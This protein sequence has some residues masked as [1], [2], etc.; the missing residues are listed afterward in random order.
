MKLRT[1]LIIILCSVIFVPMFF[2]GLI[3]YK[4]SDRIILQHTLNHLKT[5]SILTKARV[6]DVYDRYLEHLRIAVT[7]P[8][9]YRTL[10]D[11]F[12]QDSPETRQAILDILNKF[13]PVLRNAEE[14]YVFDLNGRLISGT[15][16]YWNLK[17]V[18]GEDFFQKGKT[19]EFFDLIKMTPESIYAGR[20]IFAGPVVVNSEPKA[21]LLIML[22]FEPFS[23]IIRTYLKI[24]ESEDIVLGRKNAQGDAEFVTPRR[25][26][27]EKTSLSVVPQ[28][29]KE[30]PM[31]RAVYGE[32][33]LLDNA[34]DYRGHR[35]LAA[36]NYV[37][38]PGI[39]IVVK[40][41]EAEFLK[42]LKEL[43]KITY[44][45]GGIVIFFTIF[46]GLVIARS[47]SAPIVRLSRNANR[48]AKGDLS[49]EIKT[50]VLEDDEI[51]I[52]TRSFGSMSQKLITMNKDLE[53]KVS[54]RTF[55]L[56]DRLHELERLNKISVGRELKMIELKKQVNDLSVKVGLE[57][58][59][60][61]GFLKERTTDQ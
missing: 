61:L 25:F 40:I 9:L 45:F 44:I 56:E 50:G 5:L 51:G 32:A 15:D 52:L 47:I 33:I 57:P 10:D 4:N 37:P 23:E 2:M 27:Q 8:S 43:N 58:P 11:F 16:E 22:N 12:A 28:S 20:V 42:P 19:G 31:V 21:V 35:I 53:E 13:E 24:G 38:D 6:Q 36:T 1:R 26:E 49:V 54:E 60:D 55:Q 3:L 48:I 34:I 18:A 59:F 39:G 17:G 29:R 7:R 41:D 14:M 30:I 46:I